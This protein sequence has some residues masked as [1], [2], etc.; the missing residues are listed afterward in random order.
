MLGSKQ[1]HL[2][3]LK[4]SKDDIGIPV[5]ENSKSTG[6]AQRAHVFLG[7]KYPGR[8]GWGGRRKVCW[9]EKRSA[10]LV[11]LNNANPESDIEVNAWSQ[12]N[13]ATSH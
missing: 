8:K 13:R 10:T 3:T 7:V 1:R 6:K 9:K 12:R 4:I 5:S 11:G 2:K